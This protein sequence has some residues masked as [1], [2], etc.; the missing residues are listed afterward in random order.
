MVGS[1]GR[2]EELAQHQADSQEE[3]GGRRQVNKT[4]SLKLN[5]SYKAVCPPPQPNNTYDGEKAPVN[6]SILSVPP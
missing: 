3:G 2:G 6:H 4:F 5:F 1:T